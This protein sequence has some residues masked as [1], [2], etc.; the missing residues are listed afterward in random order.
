M[1]NVANPL[2]AGRRLAYLW[3]APVSAGA[4]IAWATGAAAEAR[5]KFVPPPTILHAF[6]D[7]NTN[8]L[9][10]AG[11]GKSGLGGMT[12]PGFSDPLH[13][14]AEELRRSAIYNNYRAL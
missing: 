11:L 4:V 1:T 9:L 3:L 6:Y 12:P 5:D 10:T 7:G 14:T 2:F 8:D 13:P